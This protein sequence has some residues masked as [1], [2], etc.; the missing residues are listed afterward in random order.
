MP[1]VTL[2]GKGTTVI[3]VSGTESP[4]SNIVIAAC[5]FA[6]SPVTRRAPRDSSSVGIFCR[7]WGLDWEDSPAWYA[8]LLPLIRAGEGDVILLQHLLKVPYFRLNVALALLQR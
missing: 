3:S 8:D 6:Y 2:I 1:C 5:C 7:S 4:L